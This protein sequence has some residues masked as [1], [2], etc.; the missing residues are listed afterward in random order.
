MGLQITCNDHPEREYPQAGGS[1]RHLIEVM[2][3]SDL[4]GN[5]QLPA[6]ERRE[7]K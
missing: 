7:G 6:T 1:G 4:H 5:M 2:I 3:W